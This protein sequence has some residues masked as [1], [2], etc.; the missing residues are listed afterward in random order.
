MACVRGV[1]TARVK[2]DPVL[3]IA[4]KGGRCDFWDVGEY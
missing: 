1:E 3:A 4:V 2:Q